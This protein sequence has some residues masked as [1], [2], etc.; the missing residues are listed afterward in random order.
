METVMTLK[1][2]LDALT[3]GRKIHIC[4]EDVSG[5]MSEGE[6]NIPYHN[7]IHDTVFCNHAK[8]S[9]ALNS[10]CFS[11][12]W[13]VSSLAARVKRPFCGECPFGISEMVYPVVRQNKTLCIIHIGNICRDEHKTEIAI[14][15][16]YEKAGYSPEKH[17]KLISSCESGE[18]K[19][20]LSVAKLIADYILE[21]APE[22]LGGDTH[23]AIKRTIEFVNEYYMQDIHLSQI[24]DACHINEKYL[25]RIFK[26]KTGLSFRQYLT[27]QRFKQVEKRLKSGE[28]SITEI[29]LSC[30]FEEIT[31]FNHLFKRTYGISPSEYREQNKASNKA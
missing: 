11:G 10:Y 6:L 20:Y 14:R 7:R 19:Q 4:I 12:K 9:G 3:V 24:A 31:Y 30:G 22:K 2:L 5:V 28:E 8:G 26:Q 27:E 21:K 16:I 29:A 13:R 23:W 25:G 17:I 15:K 1:E 18:A